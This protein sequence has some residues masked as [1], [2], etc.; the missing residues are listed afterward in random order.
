MILWYFLSSTLPYFD[1]FVTKKKVFKISTFGS[2]ARMVIPNT[3]P[4][5][6][7][8]QQH[9]PHR[10]WV[11]SSYNYTD[12]DCSR[13]WNHW[14]VLGMLYSR[15]NGHNYLEKRSLKQDKH[16]FLLGPCA[17]VLCTIANAWL[18]FRAPHALRTQ[19]ACLLCLLALHDASNDQK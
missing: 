19:S 1:G 18:R 10:F 9:R 11:R 4:N 15:T 7:K 3:C 13:S 14:F 5:L 8:S 2:G 16:E 12:S 6:S 17:F